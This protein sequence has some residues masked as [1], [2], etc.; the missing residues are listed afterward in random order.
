MTTPFDAEFEKQTP[1]VKVYSNRDQKDTTKGD[2]AP[3]K[4]TLDTITNKVDR[5]NEIIEKTEDIQSSCE[6]K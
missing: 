3:V 4:T 2:K 6:G 5:D 1:N